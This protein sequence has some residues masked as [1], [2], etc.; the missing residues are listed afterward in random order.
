[1]K[2]KKSKIFVVIFL[3][4][5]ILAV[6]LIS[7]HKPIHKGKP[8]ERW[9]ERPH[10]GKVKKEPDVLPNE[11]MAYQRVYP[12]D[13]IKLDNYLKSMEDAQK[14]HEE[15]S[16]Y[17]YSWEL[18]GPTNIG[19]R[20]T[21]LAVDPN[22]LSTFYVGA[23]SGGVYKTING[24]ASWENIFTDVPVISIGAVA[25][26][27][28]NTNTL[29]VGTGE[30]NASSYS[31]LGNGVY[32]S[33]NGGMSWD[34]I[35]LEQSG[36]IGRIVVD[37]M[38]SQRVFV[39][40]CGNLFSPNSE[41]GVYRSDDGGQTWQRKLFIND[42]TAAV[43]IVQDPTNPN[44]L[45][46]AMWE[47]M[48]GLTYRRSF[49]PSSG[50]WK[51]ENGGDTWT[52]LTN[53][54]PTGNDVGRIGLAI[55]K[56]NPDRLY[57][58]YDRANQVDVFKTSDGGAS[59]T[60]TNDG[61]L[62]GINSTF[63][64][65]FGQIRVDPTNPDIVYVMG[66]Y[67]YRTTNGGN[68]W[69][70]IA[71]SVHVDHHAMY[72]DDDV[73]FILEGNDGGL[74]K[75][76]TNGSS[77]T[78]INNLPMTQFYAIEIDQTNPYRIYGGT[79]DN[80]TIRTMTGALDDWD[81][82][83][84]GDGFYCLVDYT[85][86]NRIFAEYQWGNLY[87]STNGGSYFSYIANSMSGDRTNWSSPYVM[88]PT[89]PDILYFGTYRVWKTTSGGSG[90]SAVSGDL[91]QGDDISGYHTISTMAI[92]K[93]DPS[94]IL[95]GSDDGRVHISVNSGSSWTNIS[96][97]LPDRWITR[98]ACDPHNANTIYA[99]VSG[100]RWDEEAPHVFRS[101]NLGLDWV[102]ISGNLPEM[103]VNCI[104]IDP[105]IQNKLF[106][107]TDSGVFFSEDGGL[108]WYSLSQGIPNV[109]VTDMKIYNPDRFMVIGTYGCSAYKIDL[110]DIIVSTDPEPEEDVLVQLYQ[111]YP[112]PFS[113]SSHTST[114]IDFSLSTPGDVDI[115]IYNIKGQK[116]KNVVK[117]QMAT[118]NHST[119]W[120]GTDEF[121]KSVS[122]GVYLYKL[123]VN[124]NVKQIKRCTIIK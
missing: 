64:W 111:N 10:G 73:L 8:A 27:Q 84:G 100:F 56:S 52:E 26:D 7:V 51:T 45:Y 103:P 101:N 47:R 83:L 102:D 9:V 118:G 55:A 109:P 59:W 114:Q 124:G 37:Y 43:D 93:L 13:K 49:G 117:N 3:C 66:V 17:K 60:A 36:Y 79:Q 77:W 25:L 22:D 65:Y 71:Y 86:P 33:T 113:L 108:N 94:I 91:T 78:K 99:T 116:I 106:V 1:M 48:R 21:D 67:L 96:A 70:E 31:F 44:I 115:T 72:I 24:G 110:D 74:Y 120:N 50:I 80:N 2:I 75:S 29:Y 14:L 119:Q 28:N 62:Q 98:V 5:A 76:T 88:H 11:W 41:R 57:A 81:A 95:T 30:A 18:V 35:G 23:A 4:A 97:G 46:A 54:L 38:N 34:N 68:S 61:A 121:G 89:N 90:W 6:V 12:Y 87:R 104:A 92:S 122:T 53:G 85:N 39:A 58:F 42:S 123:S 105:N 32:K 69:S 107:G 63:G 19:G 40:A 112:N 20:I 16:H 82:I 15:S